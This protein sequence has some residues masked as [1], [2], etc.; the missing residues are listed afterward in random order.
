MES[1][2]FPASRQILLFG[3]LKSTTVNHIDLKEASSLNT[4]TTYQ[5][6]FFSMQLITIDLNFC[7]HQTINEFLYSQEKRT[8]K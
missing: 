7:F 1:L 6:F 2:E 4:T 3:Q 8:W 5:Q